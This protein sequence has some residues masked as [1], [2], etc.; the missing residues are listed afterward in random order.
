MEKSTETAQCQTAIQIEQPTALRIIER[1]NYTCTSQQHM[2]STTRE[3]HS[4]IDVA[5]MLD[6]ACEAAI[7]RSGG[8]GIGAGA[9]LEVVFDNADPDSQETDGEVIQSVDNSVFAGIPVGTNVRD[10][11]RFINDQ[12][13]RT[14]WNGQNQIT[15]PH[16]EAQALLDRIR[17]RR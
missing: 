5:I 17:N 8:S 6:L 1:N 2:I 11:R 12:K 10:L 9:D 4:L 3:L 7:S 16:S 15:C 13:S 14:V